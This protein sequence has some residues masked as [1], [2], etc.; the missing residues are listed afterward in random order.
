MYAIEVSQVLADLDIINPRKTA[1][2]ARERA[3]TLLNA[4]AVP[5]G[6]PKSRIHM[7]LGKVGQAV[8]G[9]ARKINADLMVMGTTARKGL[10]GMVIGN[11]AERVL[12]KA[13]GDLLA[14][15]P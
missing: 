10:K 5:Y 11:S 14:V 3:T 15:K 4:L 6:I 1:K 7:P 2:E 9:V 13:R 12:N 8:N